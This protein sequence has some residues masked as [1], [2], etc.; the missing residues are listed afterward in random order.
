MSPTDFACIL[1]YEF[2]SSLP[3]YFQSDSRLSNFNQLT[4]TEQ[5]STTNAFRVWSANSRL[6]SRFSPAAAG[7]EG[8]VQVFKAEL[9]TDESFLAFAHGDG[10]GGDIILNAN[11]TAMQ[12]LTPRSE[13]YFELL[14]AAGVALGLKETTA[15]GRNESVMGRRSGPGIDG[16]PYA[17]T[18]L[19]LDF[20]VVNSHDGPADRFDS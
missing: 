10:I 6:Y 3:S 1:T 16:L 5:D 20:R 9:N 17:S 12:N 11:S 15:V 2:S 4:Q 7:N 13:G 14:R 19:P 18:P 8:E